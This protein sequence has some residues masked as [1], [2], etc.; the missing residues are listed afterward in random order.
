MITSVPQLPLDILTLFYTDSIRSRTTKKKKSARV[1]VPPRLV[2][3]EET[4]AWVWRTDLCKTEQ[5]WQGWYEGLS[6]K[7]LSCRAVKVLVLAGR[8]RMDTELTIAQM[9]GKFKL[10]IL[11]DVGHCLQED[12]RLSPIAINHHLHLLT[13]TRTQRE[14]QRFCW[15]WQNASFDTAVYKKLHN[16]I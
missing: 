9:Q 6:K 14:Q 11:P 2:S 12:V 13:F 4:G 1:S 7:F 16:N 3:Q 5:Y 15:I 10:V 8:D